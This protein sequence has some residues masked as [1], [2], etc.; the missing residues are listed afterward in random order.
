MIDEGLEI[1]SA[2]TCEDAEIKSSNAE[3][4]VRGIFFQTAGVTF[5]IQISELKIAGFIQV[6]PHWQGH[7]FEIAIVLFNS[8]NQEIVRF[9][10]RIGVESV[11]N[12]STPIIPFVAPVKGLVVAEP[13]TIRIEIYLENTLK[14]QFPFEIVQMPNYTGEA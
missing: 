8:D 4:D 3:M 5:P 9:K 1:V 10:N 12:T 7:Y 14:A 11:D 2:F 6:P 13:E